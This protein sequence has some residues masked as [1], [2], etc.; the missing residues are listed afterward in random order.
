MNGCSQATKKQAETE[1]P[2]IGGPRKCDCSTAK[3]AI[4][5]FSLVE[6][7]LLTSDGVMDD[8]VTHGLFL[9]SARMTRKMR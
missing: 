9:L 5:L 2:L 3:L 7:T 8:L 4:Q 6:N 1:S